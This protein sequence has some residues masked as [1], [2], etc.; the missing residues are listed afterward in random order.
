MI[1]TILLFCFVINI[2]NASTALSFTEKGQQSIQEEVQKLSY[3]VQQSPEVNKDSLPVPYN[4]LLLQPLM[5]KGI[6]TYYQRIPLIRTLYAARNTSDNTYFR[7]I[8]MFVDKRKDRNNPQWAQKKNETMIV[9]LAFITINFNE[10]PTKLINDVLN[11]NIP[12]GTLLSDNQVNVVSTGRSYFAIKCNELLASLTHCTLNSTLYGR[13]NTLI[14]ADNKKWLAQ[15]VEILP[16][17]V[18]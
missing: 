13:K 6:E 14:K 15:V 17:F 9:E 16:G 10:L 4:Y 8:L 12:F 3:M 5:T 1:R 2:L 11:T 7:A 18:N